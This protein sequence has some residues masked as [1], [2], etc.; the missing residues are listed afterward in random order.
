MYFI[1][2]RQKG[3]I[4]RLELQG[5]VLIR[6][7]KFAIVKR[8]SKF[9]RL[10]IRYIIGSFK[11]LIKSILAIPC[12]FIRLILYILDFIP[13]IYIEKEDA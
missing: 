4:D 9:L 3:F 7:G 2:F 12:S 5:C 13:V 1:K 11:E 10:Y 6:I 8:Y